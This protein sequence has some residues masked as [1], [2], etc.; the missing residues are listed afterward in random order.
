MTFQVRNEEIEAKLKE[1][2]RDLWGRMPQG[3]GFTLIISSYGEGGS[4]FYMSSVEREDMIK[5]MKELIEKM[6]ADQK[7]EAK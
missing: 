5:T 2:G 6:E 3:W 4:M 1:I 7:T